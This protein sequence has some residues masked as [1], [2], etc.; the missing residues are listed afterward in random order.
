MELGCTLPPG[1]LARLKSNYRHVC[2]FETEREQMRQACDDDTEEPETQPPGLEPIPPHE[3]A[4]NTEQPA[5]KRRKVGKKAVPVP[6]VEEY[7]LQF[8]PNTCA[9][10][11]ASQGHGTP[12]LKRCKGCKTTLYCFEGCQKWHRFHHRLK[13]E[14]DQE[15]EESAKGESTDKGEKVPEEGVEEAMT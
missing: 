3:T 15:A 8:P 6:I 11:G 12:D 13:C 7:C 5:R 9:N 10:C 2:R 1:F 4:T 14:A